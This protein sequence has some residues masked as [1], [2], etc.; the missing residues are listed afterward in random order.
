MK[1]L[2]LFLLGVGYKKILHFLRLDSRELIQ[3][4]FFKAFFRGEILVVGGNY[5]KIPLILLRKS[6]K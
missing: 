5:F 3:A 4:V 2:A 6:L 1:N